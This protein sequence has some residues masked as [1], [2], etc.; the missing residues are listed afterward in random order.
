M[1]KASDDVLAERRRQVEVEGWTP[2]HDDE[3][4]DGSLATAGAC[5]ALGNG[6]GVRIPH[7]ET[8]VLRAF[9]L[10]V[11]M[12]PWAHKWWK[13]KTRRHDL[14]RAG[15]LII[16]EIERL[17]RAS[18][19]ASERPSPAPAPQ[20][21]EPGMSSWDCPCG[22]LNN[23]IRRRC[24]ACKRDRLMAA[25]AAAPLVLG[26]TLFMRAVGPGKSRPVT[27][28]RKGPSE[29]RTH[30]GGHWTNRRVIAAGSKTRRLTSPTDRRKGG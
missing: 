4:G 20:P 24:H 22:A 17:D 7:E 10:V 8:G 21:S 25:D 26:E 28:E 2:E 19:I 27:E 5:Y 6:F 16:A 30:N 12:W 18:G 29:R 3:H 1:S 11:H 14:V 23:D 15:A 13:P 9:N